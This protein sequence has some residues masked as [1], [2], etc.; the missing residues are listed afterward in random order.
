[1]LRS[2]AVASVSTLALVTLSGPAHA[3]PFAGRVVDPSGMPVG[4]AHVTANHEARADTDAAGLFSIDTPRVSVEDVL[5]ASREGRLSGR[6]IVAR[7]APTSGL[8]LTLPDYP[9]EQDGFLPEGPSTCGRCHRS[10][11][12]GWTDPAVG[13]A[14]SMHAQSALNPRVLDIWRGTASGRT[15]VASCSE[16]GGRLT[17]VRDELGAD[18]ERCYVGAGLLPDMN[19]QCGHEGQPA[20]DDR[21]APPAARP[22]A[23]SDCGPCHTPGAAIRVPEELDLDVAEA[24]PVGSS[25][26]C[27]ACH[28]IAEV[29]DPNAPGVLLGTRTIRGDPPTGDPVGLGPLDDAAGDEMAS[30][31]AP[32]FANSLLCAPCHQDTYVA[33]GMSPRWAPAGVPSEQTYAE[34]LETPYASGAREAHCQDCHMPTLERLGLTIS[35]P[36]GDDGP[37]RAPSVLHGHGFPAL[38]D[39]TRRAE[40]LAVAVELAMEDGVLVARASVENRGVGHGWPSGVTSRNGVLVI[41]ASLDGAPLVASGGEALPLYAGSYDHGT[42]SSVERGP[43]QSTVT[44]DHPLDEGAVGRMLRVFAETAEIHE[45]VGWGLLRALPAAERGLVRRRALGEHRVLAVRGAEVD[46]EGVVV[47]EADEAEWALGDASRLAGAPGLGFAK[48]NVAADGTR[49]VPFWRATDI[50][51][52]NRLAPDETQ[53]SEH[54]FVLPPAAA[55]TVTVRARLLYRKAFVNLAVQRGWDGNESLVAEV[56]DTLEVGGADAGALDASSA[57]D[58]GAERDASDGRDAGTAAPPSG[59]GCRATRGGTGMLALGVLLWLGAGVVRRR[60]SRR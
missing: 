35:T 54:R 58:G 52:D 46:V 24:S 11:V 3:Q 17:T 22:T 16:V 33:A 19:P 4:G 15:D 53:R 55:G 49:D 30:G 29:L 8:S 23:F 57:V 5:V 48:V 26:T 45:H 51:W 50:L 25:V 12:E 10:Y 43:A 7:G 9:A 34:W 39:A 56:T 6:L 38:T 36:I 42:V 40:S 37:L 13:Y 21:S 31:Y 2:I 41:E 59:C 14:A 27:A 20:C 28:R 1:M 47:A 60:R 32:I 18:V 44:L